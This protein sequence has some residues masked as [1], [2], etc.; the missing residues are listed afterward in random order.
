[1][2]GRV[3]I[4]HL[5]D[6]HFGKPHYFRRPGEKGGRIPLTSAIVRALGQR[7]IDA[8]VLSGDVFS[9]PGE[10][11]DRE[12]AHASSEI[13]ALITKLGVATENVLLVPGNHDLERNADDTKAFGH[14]ET[15]AEQVGLTPAKV[16]HLPKVKILDLEPRV[17]VVL[18]DSC[19]AEG[20]ENSGIGLIG[21]EQ[22]ERAVGRLEAA[23]VDPASHIILAVLHHHLLP[24]VDQQLLSRT[25][26]RHP[27]LR[28]PSLT[29]DASE[30]LQVLSEVG[31]SLVLHGHQHEPALLE[32]RDRLLDPSRSLSIAAAGSCG[33]DARGDA[34]RQF[35][36]HEIDA[37]G[38]NSTAFEQGTRNPSRFEASDAIRL[39]RAAADALPGF[40]GCS[41]HTESAF[42]NAIVETRAADSSNLILMF[43]SVADCRKARRVIRESVEDIRGRQ[44][45]PDGPIALVELDGMYDLLGY[46]DLLVRIRTPHTFSAK[47]ACDP[48]LQAL[49]QQGIRTPSGDFNDHRIV[50]IAWELPDLD[51][52]AIR[53]QQDSVELRRTRLPAT[54]DYDRL[55]SQRV[56]LY[57]KQPDQGKDS[58]LAEAAEAIGRSGVGAFV[59]TVAV[60]GDEVVLDM[61][62]RCADSVAV[63]VLNRAIEPVLSRRK[64]QK[65]TLL[66]YAYDEDLPATGAAVPLPM[67]P[68]A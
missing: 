40:D 9:D 31:V 1:M 32:Y 23:G 6:C 15:L 12:L 41:V 61:F 24:V 68:V 5:S 43:M 39:P 62:L 7:R 8:L 44:A 3:S 50:D 42:E 13:V 14:L 58:F 26:P 38:I 55:R 57:F 52:Y 60:S 64:I 16:A 45:E 66:C 17:A 63:N 67:T 51:H 59:E 46:W 54:E 28:K 2:P 47:Y 22:R 18:L 37:G 29:T 21:E 65:Y 25:D 35:W 36:L 4:L 19:L 30:T 34:K 53:D 20:E 10:D 11:G 33:A 56:F 49:E 48:I 27:P